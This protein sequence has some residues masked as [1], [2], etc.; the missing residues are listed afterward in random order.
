MEHHDWLFTYSV[1]PLQ[2]L[3]KENDGENIFD[4]IPDKIT[5]LEQE[6]RDFLATVG[7]KW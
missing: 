4:A 2:G 7:M 3:G 1:S 6:D 5:F